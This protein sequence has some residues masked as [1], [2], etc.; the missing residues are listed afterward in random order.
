MKSREQR[1][2]NY[3]SK[4]SEHHCILINKKRTLFH[5][6][7]VLQ[8]KEDVFKVYVGKALYLD[9][10]IG[11]RLTIGRIEKQLINVRLGYCK[12]DNNL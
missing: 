2:E 6:V 11:Q 8:D 7:W 1:I 10:N 12:M 3:L 5:Y 4:Y 9:I